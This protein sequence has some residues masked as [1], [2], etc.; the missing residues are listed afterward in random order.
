MPL[1]GLKNINVAKVTKDDDTGATYDAV[2]KIALAVQADIKPSTSTEN[3]YA[4][5]QIAET[6]NQLGEIA[7]DLELG[8]LSTADQAYLLGAKVN[9]EGVLEFSANDQAPYVALGFESEKSN[10]KTRY[11]WLFK[12]KFSLPETSNKT[13]S[14]KP[15]FQ[16]EKISGVFSPRQFDGKWKVQVDSDDD[17]IGANVISNWFTAVYAPAG[18]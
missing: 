16:T 5:D 15:E 3:F 2:R 17:S 6:V 1:V 12:G 9:S 18:S 8:H 7:V 4:D 11:V 14:D 10:G 13:K